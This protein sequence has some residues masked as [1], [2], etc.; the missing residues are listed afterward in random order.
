MSR[1]DFDLHF[2]VALHILYEVN[3]FEAILRGVVY[4]VQCMCVC[5]FMNVIVDTSQGVCR[6]LE[7]QT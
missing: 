2:I 5:V 4:N 3:V 6:V 7:C 1:I